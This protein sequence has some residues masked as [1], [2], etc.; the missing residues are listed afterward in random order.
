MDNANESGLIG[1][2]VKRS[3]DPRLLT[4]HGCYV[5]DKQM[6][7]MLHVAF[8]RSDQSHAR[9]RGI[10]TAAALELP[11]VVAVFTA[12]DLDGDV[13][14][15]FATSKMPDYHPTAAACP[16]QGSLRRGSG[17]RSRGR[18]PLHR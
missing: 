4:G 14:P 2:R 9:I 16:G 1:K 11:G 8:R 12:A 15:I 7:G 5:D 13:K 6:V 17:R 18:K 10:D 3:E